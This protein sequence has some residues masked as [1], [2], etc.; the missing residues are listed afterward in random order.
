MFGIVAIITKLSRDFGKLVEG[1]LDP[2]V[3][4]PHTSR[5]NHPVACV[6]AC[7]AEWYTRIYSNAET[8]V[9]H[10]YECSHKNCL[11]GCLLQMRKVA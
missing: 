1:L 3:P 4:R 9:T 5:I 11:Y 6:K 10:L 2:K 8:L 7:E